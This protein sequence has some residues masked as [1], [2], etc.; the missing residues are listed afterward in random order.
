MRLQHHFAVHRPEERQQTQRRTASTSATLSSTVIKHAEV[1]SRGFL[2]FKGGQRQGEREQR[3]FIPVC[4]AL[5]APPA[6]DGGLLPFQESR[7]AVLL[8]SVHD[9]IPAPPVATNASA[10]QGVFSSFQFA[11]LSLGPVEATLF[12]QRRQPQSRTG[13]IPS[14]I[15]SPR[16]ATVPLHLH[17]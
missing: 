11:V 15:L 7:T 10:P 8:S 13:D 17:R 6:R 3:T 9:R 5:A 1:F 12:I 2:D 4:G 14:C 16:P